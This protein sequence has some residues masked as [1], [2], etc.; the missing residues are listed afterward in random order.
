MKEIIT[1]LK[2]WKLQVES[3]IGLGGMYLF[4]SLIY[5]NG[6]QFDRK[7]SDVDIV[8]IIPDNI[9][10]AL[11]RCEWMKKFLFYKQELEL[12]LLRLLER[13]NARTPI[14]SVIPITKFELLAD[15]H[16]SKVRNFYKD[17][18]FLNLDDNSMLQGIPNAGSDNTINDPIR[19]V[20]EFIQDSRNKY[21][22]VAS[23]G[24]NKSLEWTNTNDPMPKPIMRNAAQLEHLSAKAG[25]ADERFDL[26]VGLSYI[27]NYVFSRRFDDSKYYD[28]Y[29]WIC[30][31]RGG[32]GN[33]EKANS[34]QPDNYLFLCEI[35]FDLAID[36]SFKQ[37]TQDAISATNI[38]SVTPDE[39]T[40][41]PVVF[42][43]GDDGSMLGDIDDIHT[44][45][46]ESMVNLKWRKV[47]PFYVS[48]KELEKI[49]KTIK[50]EIGNK[51]NLARKTY[52]HAIDRKRL[53]LRISEKIAKGFEIIFFYQYLL[54]P[55]PESRNTYLILALNSFSL[56][57]YDSKAYRTSRYGGPLVA[58][59]NALLGSPFSYK[60]MF[61]IPTGDFEEYLKS[62]QLDQIMHLA[63]ENQDLLTMR[64]SL[65]AIHF[66]PLLIKNIVDNSQN[67][68]CGTIYERPDL[69]PV[70][71]LEYWQLGVH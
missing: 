23:V 6:Q 15:I 14:I 7:H 41:F 59:N 42:Y 13:D 8:V 67:E 50:K 17:N 65:L 48:I 2:D 33:K 18:S 56:L 34:L 68:S 31:R 47:P 60:I 12:N 4:G 11:D 70:C 69:E 37:P 28:L 1:C 21:L 30:L 61:G 3:S 51:S 19:Q 29:F 55:I 25:I 20:L 43:I 5:Q 27:E 39:D 58:Y 26:N 24:D 62:V 71:D 64:Q 46:I 66:V 38:L 44:S 16:K 54:F 63:S 45:I 49:D 53:L 22:S 9:K 10:R 36:L 40:A 35:L 32:R 52:A 57:C